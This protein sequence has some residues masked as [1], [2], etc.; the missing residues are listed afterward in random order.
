MGSQAEPA[1]SSNLSVLLRKYGLQAHGEELKRNGIDTV[2]A[3]ILLT[4]D[5]LTV[6]NLPDD[7]WDDLEQV[8]VQVRLESNTQSPQGV[9]GKG[10]TRSATTDGEIRVTKSGLKVKASR[11]KDG[12]GSVKK[13]KKSHREDSIAE[14]PVDGEVPKL[15]SKGSSRRDKEKDKERDTEKEGPLEEKEKKKRSK[16]ASL[17]LDTSS[18]IVKK[19]SSRT[20]ETPMSAVSMAS[21]DR[22]E[23]PESVSREVDSGERADTLGRHDSCQDEVDSQKGSVKSSTDPSTSHE[24]SLENSSSE[25]S[26]EKLE[27]SR[28]KNIQDKIVGLMKDDHGEEADEADQGLTHKSSV[29]DDASEEDDDSFESPET[30]SQR[31]LGPRKSETIPLKKHSDTSISMSMVFDKTKKEGLVTTTL[32]RTFEL[33]SQTRLGGTD[34]RALASVPDLLRVKKPYTLDFLDE[35][36]A[37]EITYRRNLDLLMD[38]YIKPMHKM[39][40]STKDV[41]T[42]KDLEGWFQEVSSMIILS[43]EFISRLREVVSASEDLEKVL[44]QRLA[45]VFDYQFKFFTIYS[46]YSARFPHT[47]STL[48]RKVEEFS[49]LKKFLTNARFES[50]NQSLYDLLVIPFKRI[51]AYYELFQR[52]IRKISD[53]SCYD[54][55]ADYLGRLSTYTQTGFISGKTLFRL[56]LEIKDAPVKIS[57]LTSFLLLSS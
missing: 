37:T 3:L 52:H 28:M 1:D 8:I 5:D 45:E 48:R 7:A 11:K 27:L 54:R 10:I 33:K 31:A 40:T 42:T 19:R 9:L 4:K 29:E 53:S 21:D 2:D 39:A 55:S 16:S 35:V 14:S 25:A 41:P 36:L 51:S 57:F 47:V 18:P 24:P 6:M 13:K 56:Q 44:D 15:K 12:E 49:K 32:G 30:P 43:G 26:V 34:F 50:G 46:A 20:P 38:V 22:G 17:S 23:E